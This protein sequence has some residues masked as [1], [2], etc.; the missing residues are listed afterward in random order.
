MKTRE[1]SC[2][3]K[4]P[5]PTCIFYENLQ[6]QTARGE[7]DKVANKTTLRGLARGSHVDYFAIGEHESGAKLMMSPEIA[8][9]LTERH[10]L[11]S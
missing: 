6:I 9:K 5:L 2:L 3:L 1:K 11:S 7:G 10:G 8:L 4:Q